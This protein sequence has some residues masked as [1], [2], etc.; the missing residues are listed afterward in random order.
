MYPLRQ[1]PATTGD[2]LLPIKPG[3]VFSARV[4][5]RESIFDLSITNVTTAKAFTVSRSQTAATIRAAWLIEAD[6]DTM[7]LSKFSTVSM[8]HCSAGTGEYTGSIQDPAWSWSVRVAMPQAATGE[9]TSS[10]DGFQISWIR[11]HN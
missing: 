9:L 11:L 2:T 7:Y 3:D 6:R 5:R 10:Q 1:V 4:S 8:D